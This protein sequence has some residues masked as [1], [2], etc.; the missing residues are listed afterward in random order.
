MAGMF[1]GLQ[2]SY[3]IDATNLNPDTNLNEIPMYRG[4]V[5]SSENVCK[6]PTADNLVPLGVVDNDERLATAL[7]DG[8][9]QAGR[10][11][12]VQLNGISMLQLGGTVAEGERV[13][14]GI[15]G[16]GLQV[17]TTAN[18]TP[19][20]YNVIGFAEKSGGI[21]DVVPVRMQYHVFTI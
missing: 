8:G 1:T 11:I 9:S 17:P 20:N 6:L 16:K 14:L 2:K 4:V 12:A 18:A 5:F 15:G 13:Y 21:G 3:K 10:Q 19:I 7:S